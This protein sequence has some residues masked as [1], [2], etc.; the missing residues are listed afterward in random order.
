MTGATPASPKRS[1]SRSPRLRSGPPR[2]RPDRASTVSSQTRYQNSTVCRTLPTRLMALAVATERGPSDVILM[3]WQ[4]RSARTRD[5]AICDDDDRYRAN[6]VRTAP[7]LRADMILGKD[8][9]G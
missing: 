4:R 8:E 5:R 9:Y 2:P 3:R 1:V 7:L 6:L